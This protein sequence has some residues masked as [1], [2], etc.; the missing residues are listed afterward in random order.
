MELVQTGAIRMNRCATLWAQVAATGILPS[1][2][3]VRKTEWSDPE[4]LTSYC[5]S[6]VR[7]ISKTTEDG[8]FITSRRN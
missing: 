4:D 6:A 3:H 5:F 7:I 1:T 8:S 2:L